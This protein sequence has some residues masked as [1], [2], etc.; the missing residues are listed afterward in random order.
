MRLSHCWIVLSIG[1]PYI[2]IAK[3]RFPLYPKAATVMTSRWASPFAIMVFCKGSKDETGSGS[4]LGS[5]GTASPRGAGRPNGLRREADPP[6]RRF[7]A[8]QCAGHH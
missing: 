7:P 8:R 3:S 5:L 4:D 1:I 2:G 6:D